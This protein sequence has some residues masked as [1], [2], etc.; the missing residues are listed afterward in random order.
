V[1]TVYK[2]RVQEKYTPIDNNVPILVIPWKLTADEAIREAEAKLG[3]LSWNQ[4]KQV[5]EKFGDQRRNIS[6]ALRIE[7][8]GTHDTNSTR[9]N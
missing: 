3:P 1:K 5:R 2:D 4:K 7:S 8:G 9:C 6:L